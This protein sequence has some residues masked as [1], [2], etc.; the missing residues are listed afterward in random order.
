MVNR[1]TG[2]NVA[3]KSK[4]GIFFTLTVLVLV[5]LFFITYTFYTEITKADSSRQRV[6]TMNNFLLSIEQDLERQVYIAGF[7]TIFLL[8]DK[9]AE[10]GTYISNPEAAFEES[11]FNGTLYGE[12]QP[13]MQG[14]T[15]NDIVL[16]INDKARK[17]NVNVT[18]ENPSLDFAQEDPWHVT[19][20]LTTSFNMRDA[21][22]L[23]AWNKTQIIKA[24][25]SV[26]NFEDPLYII[27]TNSI[28]TNQINKTVYQPFVEGTDVS[29]L[30][31]HALGSYY[32]ASPLA[33]SFLDRLQGLSQANPQGI[34][35]L[36]NLQELPSPV[37]DK[38]AVD[39]IYFSTQN[40]T[41]FHIQGMPSW[42]RLDQ[43]HLSLYNATNLTI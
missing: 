7:R 40:P 31:K 17:M 16:A 8:E 41:S 43:S 9:I 2:E 42:F 35:S 26:E 37:Q 15:F 13:I 22:G 1:N 3:M 25:I 4:K 23:A 36:V 28:V 30:T 11:F 10:T 21:N 39:Y 29:N 24:R 5:S 27:S 20:T 38:T 32:V 19:A 14:A 34:E 18:M 33:P 6:E 12:P